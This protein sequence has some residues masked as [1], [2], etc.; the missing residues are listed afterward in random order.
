M[1][2][3]LTGLFKSE[4]T[5]N[6]YYRINVSLSLPTKTL[7]RIPTHRGLIRSSQI[8]IFCSLFN[9]FDDN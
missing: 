1:N 6:K 8:Q 9:K 7:K 5:M 3:S 2:T 4:V